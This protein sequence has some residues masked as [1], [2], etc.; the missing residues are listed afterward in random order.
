MMAQEY[1]HTHARN[2]KA[3]FGQAVV[4]QAFNPSTWEAEAG[5]FEFKASLVY[6]VSS[7]TARA[8]QR[9][10]VSK[11]TKRSIFYEK[12][13]SNQAVDMRISVCLRSAL[14]YRASSRTAR[15]M[16]RNAVLKNQLSSH[17]SLIPSTHVAAHKCL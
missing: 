2:K 10:P 13:L 7:R 16:Q 1:I 11:K 6:R 12:H 8:T 5:G 14:V 3:Y 9:N 15:T 4:A 17:W